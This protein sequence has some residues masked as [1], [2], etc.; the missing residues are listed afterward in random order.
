[1]PAPRTMMLRGARSF[2]NAKHESTRRNSA[3][4]YL[5]KKKNNRETTFQRP[6]SESETGAGFFGTPKKGRKTCAQNITFL[7]LSL[8]GFIDFLSRAV[9]TRL[10]LL[11]FEEMMRRRRPERGA[12]FKIKEEETSSSLKAHRGA[13]METHYESIPCLVLFTAFE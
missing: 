6:L 13:L 2:P 12:S 11:V 8:C 5:L 3:L 10:Q 1:M 7:S 4:N 9:E